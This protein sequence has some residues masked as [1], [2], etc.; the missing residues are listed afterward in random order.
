M[1]DGVTKLD[2]I[3]YQPENIKQA[4]NFRKLLLAI[5]IDI[6]VLLVK[7]ADRIHNIRTINHIQNEKKKHRLAHET[8]EIYAPLAERIGV[9]TFKMNCKI[10]H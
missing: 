1:V 5:S 7:L 10:Y 6:R 8:M 3:E 2:K 4:E 9:H